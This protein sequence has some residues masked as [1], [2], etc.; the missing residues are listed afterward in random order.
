[1]VALSGRPQGG[2]VIHVRIGALAAVCHRMFENDLQQLAA[3]FAL[4]EAR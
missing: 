3:H 4:L 1:L 2:K